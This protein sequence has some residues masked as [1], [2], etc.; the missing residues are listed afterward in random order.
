MNLTSIEHKIQ[1][2][3]VNKS[4]SIL[5]LRWKTVKSWEDLSRGAHSATEKLLRGVVLIGDELIVA[6]GGSY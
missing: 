3:A 1:Q 4:P 2:Y 6:G 5:V